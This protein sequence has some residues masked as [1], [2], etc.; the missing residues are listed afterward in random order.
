M[1][2]TTRERLSEAIDLF[3][4]DGALVVFHDHDDP[5][6]TTAEGA[7]L[8]PLTRLDSQH[9]ELSEKVSKANAR[10]RGELL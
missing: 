6:G 8:P 5:C 7:D 9:P 2:H 10:S 3:G 1:A 4:H